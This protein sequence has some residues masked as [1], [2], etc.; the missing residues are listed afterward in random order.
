M[1][2]TINL[3]FFSFYHK[4]I[5]EGNIPFL[6]VRQDNVRAIEVNKKLGFVIRADVYF[7]IFKNGEV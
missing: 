5:R 3:Q 6:H 2:H 4:A 7:A 1:L